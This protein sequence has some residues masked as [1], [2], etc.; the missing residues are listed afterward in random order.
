[1]ILKRPLFIKI[2]FA[3]LCFS[4]SLSAQNTI[5]VVTHYMQQSGGYAPLYNGQIPP[6]YKMLFEGTYYLESEEYQEGTVVY[7]GKFYTGLLLNLNAHLDELYIRMSGYYT[8]SILL[9]KLVTSFT[10]GDKEFV[11]I[12]KEDQPSVPKEGFYRV[13]YA[14]TALT[15]L[16]KTN[17]LLSSVSAASDMKA[18]HSFSESHYYYLLKD[19][20]FYPVTR[21]ASLLRALQDQRGPLNRFIRENKLKFTSEMSQ[22]KDNT[23]VK[24]GQF[25]DNLIAQ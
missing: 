19:G 21:K 13:L 3:A 5:P 16:K 14:G 23:I 11:H 1:M 2:F 7:N 25:Y 4:F 17:K 15:V 10:L 12:T 22:V 9:K 6:A 20:I 18:S 8:S 24:C